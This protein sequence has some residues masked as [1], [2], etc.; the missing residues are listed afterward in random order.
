[1]SMIRR[2]A[3]AHREVVNGLLRKHPPVLDAQLTLYFRDIYDHLVHAT[4]LIEMHREL[5]TGLL[6]LNLSATAHRTNEIVKML[7]IYA[8]I[9]LPLNVITGYFGMNFDHLPF[10]HDSIAVP[11]VTFSLVFIALASTIFFRNRNW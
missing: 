6:D 1:L 10:T 4:E 5:L 8:T 3:V 9:L 11:I 2:F 7:T